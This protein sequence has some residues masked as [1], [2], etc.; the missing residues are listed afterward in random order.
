MKLPA[1]DIIIS[2]TDAIGD[3]ILTLPLAGYLKSLKPESKIYFLGK[4]YT[5]DVVSC[6]ENIDVFLD[7]N[8]IRVL[9]KK[10][11]TAFF[12]N[13]GV[14]CIFFVFPDKEIAKLAFQ[15]GIAIRVGTAHRWFHWL[16]ANRRPFFSRKKSDLHEAQLNFL[17]LK[18]FGDVP[19][20]DE[21]TLFSLTGMH[22]IQPLPQ[23]FFQQISK[24]K[25]N[26]IIHP[27]SRGS[28]REWGLENFANLIRLLSPDKYMIYI[29]G[30]KE[31]AKTMGIFL[32]DLPSHVVDM[33]GKLSLKEFISFIS[34]CDGL[35]ACSTGPLHIAASLGKVAVGLY[36]P[37]RP[38]HPGRWK[39][40]GPQT[41]VF[42][43]EK[44]CFDCKKGGKCVCIENI[45]AVEV[46]QYLDNK[47]IYR[48]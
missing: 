22:R 7:W 31:E 39:P 15:A 3:V 6:C 21:K 13:I 28:S 44:T 10:E 14:T 1:G 18:P 8:E 29:S 40:I 26:I 4:T 41:K 20:F 37:I 32:N 38:L 46:A 9:G 19:L 11:K 23:S 30:T 17:L 42:C 35:V 36:P 27:G 2:R 24:A 47:T 16:Y 25:T 48:M 33:T 43:I 12:R 5:K 45:Q 34:A